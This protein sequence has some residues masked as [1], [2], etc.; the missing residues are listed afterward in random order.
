MCR[1]ALWITKEQGE[2]IMENLWE[3]VLKVLATIGGGIAG[4]FGEWTMLLTCLVIVITMDYLTGW[5]VACR[6]LSP[7][8]E[9]GKL[10][11]KAGFDGLLRKG[12]IILVV[13]LATVLDKVVGNETAIFQTATVC[14]YIANE[15][16]SIAE[17]VKLMGLQLPSFLV[18]LLEALQKK[19]DEPP[20]GG[21]MA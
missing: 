21:M 5:I 17:N 10:S 12:M 14:W 19:N 18:K 11:S 9:D 20:E 7:K 4:F 2:N 6:G 1:R 8:S 13:L 16:L 15:S 3:K